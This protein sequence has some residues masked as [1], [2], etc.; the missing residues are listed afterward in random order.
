MYIYIYMCVYIYI[1]IYIIHIYN[2]DDNNNN[3]YYYYY[4][5]YLYYC[6]RKQADTCHTTDIRLRVPEDRAECRLLEVCAYLSR[7]LSL[8]LSL[9]IYIYIYIYIHTHTC[10]YIYAYMN[11]ACWRSPNL[12]TRDRDSFSRPLVV[13]I[14]VNKMFPSVCFFSEPGSPEIRVV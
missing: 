7:S 3:I 9:S 14:L 8:S 12:S 1:Y 6:Y 2:S 5:C 4:Y 11:A 10:I 13:F